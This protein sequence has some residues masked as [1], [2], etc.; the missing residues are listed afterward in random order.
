[1]KGK[2][3]TCLRST[4]YLP[5]PVSSASSLAGNRSLGSGKQETG[6]S[7]P[8]TSGLPCAAEVHVY[9]EVA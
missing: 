4:F 7:A 5:F 9:K 6:K 2:P 1:M 3:A 8:M